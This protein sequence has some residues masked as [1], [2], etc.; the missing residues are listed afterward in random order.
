ML[1]SK[2]NFAMLNFL[3]LFRVVIK[4]TII[5]FIIMKPVSICL[6]YKIRNLSNFFLSKEMIFINENID[7]YTIEYAASSYIDCFLC[8]I[9]IHEKVSRCSIIKKELV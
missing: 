7:R 8:E 5:V 9:L 3:K 4:F 1:I 2:F 6:I